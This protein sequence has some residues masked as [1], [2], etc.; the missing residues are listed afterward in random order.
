M[1]KM[2]KFMALAMATMMVFSVAG[3]GKGG[4]GGNKEVNA[5][6]GGKPVEIAYWNSGM[7][8]AY[9][10]KL[11]EAFNAKQSDWFVYYAASADSS[12]LVTSFG[13]DDVDSVDLYFATKKYDTEYMAPLDDLL[14]SKPEG[15]S[16]SIKEKFNASYLGYEQ[17]ADDH[18]YTLTWGG[19]AIGIVY[20]KELFEEASIGT[21]PRTT[22]ELALV[23][24][25]LKEADI[26][27]MTH[28][29][30]N[31]VAPGYWEYMMEVLT[32]QY[33]GLDYYQNTFFGNPTKDI[34]T[35]KDGR[36]ATIKAM[37]QI[38]SSEYV[39]NGANAQDSI[40]AQT[41]F[42]NS[43]IGMMITGS[44]M[45][46]EMASVGKTDKYGVMKTPVVS[47]IIDKLVTVESETELRNLI[48]AID[49]V[50]DGTATLMDYETGYG[51]LI[52]GKTVALA[53]WDYVE[54][55][56]NST[57]SN[58]AHQVCWIP[59]YSD[60]IDGAKE[61]LKFYYSDEGIKI[62]ADTLHMTLPI[63][64][65]EGEI[66][67]SNWNS[68]EK[69]MFDLYMNADQIVSSGDMGKHSLFINGGAS[70]F[71]GYNFGQYFCSNNPSD[72][73]TGEE[74]W[75]EI[76]KRVETNYDQ[77]MANIK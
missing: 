64:M 26:T 60:A 42:L 56:R 37:E 6:N 10:D 67:T 61:F 29:K 23:C 19:G 22:N 9:L 27:A 51:Y 68:F 11:I 57:A 74:A 73:I 31:T 39:Q 2:K 17:A 46:N 66:D 77:W 14:E 33:D 5:T 30:G 41:T 34:L 28:S 62:M 70:P 76:V 25:T 35:A 48:T 40:T 12:S 72:R 65:S 63:A 8:T 38:L 21:L 43:K 24:D 53:D 55:A 44:W 4:K 58:Y 47:S 7:G 16:K 75:D 3:C 49:A 32:A 18:Y 15:E 52:N 54:A 20:N 59:N 1:K 36:Y 69:D 13:L 50:T 71:A 45:S